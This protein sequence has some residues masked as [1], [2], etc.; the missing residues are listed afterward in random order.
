MQV[1]IVIT[2]PES[3]GKSTLTRSLAAHF[4]SEWAG[5]YARRYLEEK[6]DYS[7]NDLWEIAIGQLQSE[8]ALKGSLVF[9]DTNLYVIK[10]WSEFVFNNCDNRILSL[11]AQRPYHLYLLCDIDM[12][13]QDDPLREHPDPEDRRKLFGMYHADLVA[14]NTRWIVI[15]GTE[16]ER[17]RA[18]IHAVNELI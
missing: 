15:R 9:L 3:T 11:I 8:D 17:L 14:Q 6:I 16:E 4:K 1:K 12:P 13:W 10:T 2:G 5:E 7:Y 18:A